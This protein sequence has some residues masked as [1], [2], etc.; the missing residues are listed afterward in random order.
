MDTREQYV[1]VVQRA[2]PDRAA[3]LAALGRPSMRMNAVPV[4]PH[5]LPLGASRI[6]GL[7]DLPEGMAWPSWQDRPLD[8]LAQINLANVAQMPGAEDLPSTGWLVFFWDVLED[9]ISGGAGRARD[10]W[11]VI[12]VPQGAGTL[13]RRALP[14]MSSPGDEREWLHDRRPGGFAYCAVRF[15]SEWTPVPPESTHA[16]VLTNDERK[17]Y[18][19][20]AEAWQEEASQRREAEQGG[21]HRLLGHPDAIQVNVELEAYCAATGANEEEVY[22]SVFESGDST[23]AQPALRWRLLL[24]LDTDPRAKMMW[25]DL[26][27][28]Y[29]MLPDDALAARRFDETQMV[30]Q[31]G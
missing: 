27:M 18:F 31:C 11:Q 22:R 1:A 12:Y 8:F 24:Q 6:G 30:L 13:Q 3:F 28:L 29:F 25:G 16:V 20:A 17:A 5:L 19:E 14:T 23:L 15:T 26:G 4:A 2:L 21:C 9:Q 10:S 7:P